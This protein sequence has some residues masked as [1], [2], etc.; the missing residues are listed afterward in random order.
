MFQM[1]VSYVDISREEL[2]NWL[3][4]LSYKWTREP[5]MAGIY[6]IH[7]SDVVAIKLSS[8]QT[9]SSG[10]MGYAE[11][12]MKLSLVS[13]VTKQLL[14]RK[15]A[16]RAHF[17]RTL[18]WKRTWKEGVEHWATV[19]N[20]A[21]G[22]YDRIAEIED[23]AEYKKNLLKDIESVFG[24]DKNT[25]LSSMHEKVTN[26]SI[27]TKA[28]EEAI[29]KFVKRRPDPVSRSVPAPVPAPVFRPEPVSRPVSVPK[30]FTDAQ[31]AVRGVVF[32]PEQEKAMARL[33]ALTEVASP[34]DKTF[35][36]IMINK[37][38]QGTKLTTEEKQK[39]LGL[40]KDYNIR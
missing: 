31:S 5:R 1:P 2:E 29:A 24:W 21:K 40:L 3:D 36:L 7:L 27:L 32:T 20:N 28:Q 25:F 37:A 16:D 4:S 38:R 9:A 6:Y 11:G 22:F 26:N 12:S 8:T 13:L 15:D 33:I 10:S 19:Y 34:V 39:L 23:R 30:T 18:N 17:K 35:T 14:N